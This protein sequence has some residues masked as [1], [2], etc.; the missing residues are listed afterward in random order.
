MIKKTI[1]AILAVSLVMTEFVALPEEINLF[2][3]S[4]ITAY[5]ETNEDFEYYV[6]DDGTIEIVKYNGSN[7]NVVIPEKIDGKKVTHLW[8]VFR[9]DSKVK[10]VYIPASV[11]S[12]QDICRFCPIIES[13]TVDENNEVYKSID[14]VL[15]NKD[16]SIVIDVPRA[17]S[18]FNIP[19]S[20]TG[21]SSDGFTDGTS[22]QFLYNF[23]SD[24]HISV[25]KDNTKYLA[26]D[27]VLYTKSYFGDPATLIWVSGSN[28]SVTIPRSIEYISTYAYSLKG[29]FGKIDNIFVEEGSKYFTSV[30]GVLYNYQQTVL[31][32]CP[33]KKKSLNIPETVKMIGSDSFYGNGEIESITIPEGVESIEQGAFRDCI[34]LKNIKF[35]DKTY[36]I[37]KFALE[38]TAWY[39]TQPNGVVY[40]GK[41]AYSYKNPNNTKYYGDNIEGDVLISY[42]GKEM[43]TS[44]LSYVLGDGYYLENGTISRYGRDS[45]PGVE[46][47]WWSESSVSEDDIKYNYENGQYIIGNTK[48][49]PEIEVINPQDTEYDYDDIGGVSVGGGSDEEYYGDEEEISD[50]EEG[51]WYDDNIHVSS[52]DTVIIKSINGLDPKE[53]AELLESTFN[54]NELANKE[55]S[56]KD[57]TIGIANGFSFNDNR[58][59]YV[60]NIFESLIIPDT[61]EYIGS[62]AFNN[63]EYTYDYDNKISSHIAS[64]K[65]PNKDIEVGAFAFDTTQWY[66]KQPDG[67]VYLGPVC[68]GM[69]GDYYKVFPENYELVI[70]DGTISIADMAFV[71]NSF[72]DHIS[73]VIMPDSVVRVG[74]YAFEGDN[75]NTFEFSENML[76]VGV[77]AFT[78]TGWYKKQAENCTSD[79]DSCVIYAGKVAIGSAYKYTDIRIKEGTRG[80]ADYF[81]SGDIYKLILPKSLEYSGRFGCYNNDDNVNDYDC[82]SFSTS[83]GNWIYRGAFS[84]I[85]PEI[86]CY[87]NSVGEDFAKINNLKYEYLSAHTHLYTSTI[88][89]AA[90]C[91]E[92][93]VKTYTCSCGDT[94]TETIP[95]LTTHTFG[96]WT[97]TKAAA[98]TAE[99]TETRIC[100]VCGETE[101]RAIAKTA[102]TYTTKIVAPTTTTQGY[103][104]HTCTVC[105]DSFKDTYTAK[106]TPKAESISKATVSG[107]S[108]K[109][110]TGSAIK[111]TPVVK[112][113]TKT[114]KSGTD[115]TLAYKNNTKVGTATVT[116]T[117][118]GSYTGTISKTFKINAASI[119]KAAVSG[120]SN[121][122]YTGKAITQNPTVKLGSKTLKKGTDYT[123][124]YKNNKAVG[125]ATV[126]I[127]G[128]GNYTGSIS[129][130]FK[131]NPKKTTLKSAASPKTKQ[132]KVTYSKVSGVTG[133]QTVYSKSSKFTKAT[134]KTASSKNTSKTIS[135]LTK[136]KTYYVKVRTYKTVNGTKYYSGYSAVKKIKIK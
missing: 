98:C 24:C 94:Y 45:D 23:D 39:N 49:I 122:T 116:I 25:D 34:K 20:V 85:L 58:S 93:G 79:I 95:K 3:K 133:Y 81:V 31:V 71:E 111:Q 114:L 132:L 15:Y 54:R 89:K 59:Y 120:L 112:L 131:I 113:G 121:K 36:K 33:G 65:L 102:H 1:A 88:T 108:A 11:T 2:G 78:Y 35:S 43:S 130:T 99:G 8:Y 127:K 136:G 76:K 92:A 109:T 64:I 32:A 77:N 18:E 67:V 51:G 128:K 100:S 6:L 123:V 101:T 74:D 104:L 110:Y 57:G 66:A 87:Q 68:L 56:F 75:I 105:S 9:D 83:V 26:I 106:L 118:K 84:T 70:K 21:F 28:T 107:I 4:S 38:N 91:K 40:A 12:I 14:G 50:E 42:N 72:A 7:S 46:S 69:K 129:K 17:I 73:K 10:S 97:V 19:A 96:N 90:T 86:Y 27:D 22:D 47:S 119:A 103:T 60:F 117:G 80:I 5:A 48:E 135:G 16:V 13:V 30:D 37:G 41:V 52:L 63:R 61:I 126:T 124:S 125:K 44:S 55:L 134:T 62:Y 29:L 115:Y 82:S 53:Y